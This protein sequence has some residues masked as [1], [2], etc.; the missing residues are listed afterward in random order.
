L[1]RRRR[2]SPGLAIPPAPRTLE[3]GIVVEQIHVF[4]FDLPVPAMPAPKL[5]LT[6]VR[7]TAPRDRSSNSMPFPGLGV[8]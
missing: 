6:S 2:R 1:G 3:V 7:N 5:P 8:F 4:D